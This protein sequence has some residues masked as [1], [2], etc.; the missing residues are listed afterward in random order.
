MKAATSNIWLQAREGLVQLHVNSRYL[1]GLKVNRAF[2]CSM[3]SQEERKEGIHCPIY[4][5]NHIQCKIL[6]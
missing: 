5:K 2:H 4:K 1:C 3:K 6:L